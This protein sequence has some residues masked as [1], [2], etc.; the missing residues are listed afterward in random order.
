MPWDRARCKTQRDEAQ[1]SASGGQALDALVQF[2]HQ[3]HLPGEHFDF[4]GVLVHDLVVRKLCAGLVVHFKS[5]VE[6]HDFQ[7]LHEQPSA[8]PLAGLFTVLHPLAKY[9]PARLS[10]DG[11]MAANSEMHV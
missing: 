1:R 7:K 9:L 2:R 10:E 3:R 4:F 11:P 5:L 6:V 8:C